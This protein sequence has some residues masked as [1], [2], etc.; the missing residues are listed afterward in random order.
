[1]KLF[2]RKAVALRLLNLVVAQPLAP[3]WRNPWTSVC[4][5]AL[6]FACYR[7]QRKKGLKIE[8]RGVKI[9]STLTCPTEVLMPEWLIVSANLAG[10]ESLAPLVT[11]C[12]LS[13]LTGSD[14]GARQALEFSL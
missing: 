14:E 11:L 10:V 7:E 9:A 8:A 5:T 12:G 4:C 13:V 2:G 3:F 1:M 6:Q